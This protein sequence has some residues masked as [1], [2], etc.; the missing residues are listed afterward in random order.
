MPDT[1]DAWMAT[2]R[3]A[4]HWWAGAGC[5]L[6][7]LRRTPARLHALLAARMDYSGSTYMYVHTASATAMCEQRPAASVV[8]A[9]PGNRGVRERAALRRWRAGDPGRALH[10]LPGQRGCVVVFADGV[11]VARHVCR[12]QGRARAALCVADGVGLREQRHNRVSRVYMSQCAVIQA[13]KR[14]RA[15]A[16]IAND[17]CPMPTSPR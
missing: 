4:R 10:G 14:R 5:S 15:R 7:S 1:K 12:R 6:R 8:T 9:L 13:G 16:E 3:A 17:I 2:W 11:Y